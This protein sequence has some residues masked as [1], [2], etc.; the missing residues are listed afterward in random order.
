MQR[1][2]NLDLVLVDAAWPRTDLRRDLALAVAGSMLIALLARLEI[3]LQP[4]PITGQTFGVLLVGALLGS[5][6]G[7]AATLTY[8]GWG[9]IGLP[10]FAG[11]S[12]G[13]ARLVG[14]TGGYLVGFVVAAFMVGWLSERGWDRRVLTTAMAML[15]GTILIYL[16]G[17]AW[18]SRFVGWDRVLQLGLIPF[19]IGDLLKVALAALAL[20]AGWKLIGSVRN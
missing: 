14:P 13:V 2:G 20:P 10:V 8:L 12:S 3:P 18:L 17:I 11:G 4:V 5:R 7:A 6:L 1:S 16:P 15:L 19:L 9:A